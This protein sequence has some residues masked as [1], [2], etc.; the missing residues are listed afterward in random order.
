MYAPTPV[1]PDDLREGTFSTVAIAQFKVSP[2]GNV[3]V[4]LLKP[5]PNPRLNQI[6]LDTLRQWKFFPA[7]KSGVAIASQFEVRI[8]I[9]VQ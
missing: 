2:E 9:A 7:M 3:E 8:P 4:T 5:T 1:I 6:L